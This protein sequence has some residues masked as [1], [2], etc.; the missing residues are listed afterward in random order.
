MGKATFLVDMDGFDSGYGIYYREITVL[1]AY[2]SSC[3]LVELFS[4]TQL[5]FF[6]RF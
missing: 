6:T 5:F 2:L 1:K 3:P 4:N